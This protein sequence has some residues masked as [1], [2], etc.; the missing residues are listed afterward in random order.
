MNTTIAD[1][2]GY[3]RR[4]YHERFQFGQG[5]ED[6][7]ATLRTVPPVERWVDLG[8]GSE[9]LLW[10]IALRA[11][12]L[13]AVDADPHR[14]VLLRQMAGTHRLRGVYRTAL[15]LCEHPDPHTA[16]AT[17]RASL[18]ATIVADCL[19][20]DPVADPRLPERGF[21]LVTQI[22][23]LGLCRTPEHFAAC[24]TSLRRLLAPGGWAVGANWVPARSTGRVPLTADLY[25]AAADRAGLRLHQLGEVPISGDADFTALWIYVGRSL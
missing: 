17:R 15:E 5:T 12:R 19:T 11:T 24:F 3:W 16:W 8:C 14:L 2:D 4:Y 23:L 1:A 7:V 25:Q 18:H 13:V 9:S 21:D 10:A 22:G 6:L 20:G